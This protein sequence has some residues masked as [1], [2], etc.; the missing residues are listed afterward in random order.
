VKQKVKK[1]KK[2]KENNKKV[3][4]GVNQ[5]ATHIRTRAPGS[6]PGVVA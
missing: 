5:P 1:K 2:E 3:L 4:I 6:G